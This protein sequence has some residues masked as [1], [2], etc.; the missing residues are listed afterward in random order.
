ME[1]R[2][3]FGLCEQQPR[4]GQARGVELVDDLLVF[5]PRILLLLVKIEQLLPRRG[6]VLIGRQHRNQSADRQIA[7]DHQITADREEEERGQLREE[8]VE[9]LDK[10]FAPVDLEANVVDPAQQ[11]GKV[12]QLQLYRVIGMDLDD[13]GVRLM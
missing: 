10:K 6:Q 4:I 9:K 3:A 1:P 8:V 13:A 12:G 7:A 2:D 5:D 11:V